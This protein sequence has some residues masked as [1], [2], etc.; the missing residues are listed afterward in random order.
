M[1]VEFSQSAEN[2]CLPRILGDLFI[3]ALHQVSWRG[4]LATRQISAYLHNAANEC[5]RSPKL[6]CQIS[7]SDV[8][9]LCQQS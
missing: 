9:Y 4:I 8:F 2:G 1:P 6:L 3:L 7:V 5:G